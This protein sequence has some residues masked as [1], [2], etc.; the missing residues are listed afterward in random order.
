MTPDLPR[1]RR[2]K[3]VCT[4]GPASVG[5]VDALLEAGMDVAR[6]NF[7]HGTPASRATAAARVR[8]AALA[9]GTPVAVF[10]DLAGPKIRLGAAG[11]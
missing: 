3:L 7:S 5:Q 2:T 11:R 9:A 8:A 10:A 1:R 6:L 4:I